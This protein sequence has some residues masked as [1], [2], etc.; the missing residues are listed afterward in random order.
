MMACTCFQLFSERR[1]GKTNT[2]SVAA[3]FS[4]HCCVCHFLNISKYKRKIW[5]LPRW[6]SW[7]WHTQWFYLTQYNGSSWLSAIKE[8]PPYV[9]CSFVLYFVIHLSNSSTLKDLLEVLSINLS[10][11]RW[12]WSSKVQRTRTSQ[13]SFRST[14]IHN[15]YFSACPKVPSHASEVKSLYD[16]LWT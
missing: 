1:W 9:L 14:F 5:L 11:S 3:E 12:K 15:N 13:R 4:A 6:R 7:K 2:Y 8:I 10:P 16:K